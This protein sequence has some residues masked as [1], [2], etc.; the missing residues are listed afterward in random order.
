[1]L[2]DKFKRKQKIKKDPYGDIETAILIKASDAP[3]QKKSRAEKERDGEELDEDVEPEY[4]G[5]HIKRRALV[6]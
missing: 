3:V 4:K 5:H 2:V 6:D 1:M